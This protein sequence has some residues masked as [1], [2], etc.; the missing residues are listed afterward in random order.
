MKINAATTI[1]TSERASVNVCF[2]C[3]NAIELCKSALNTSLENLFRVQR[4]EQ[5]LPYGPYYIDWDRTWSRW[6]TPGPARH[7]QTQSR[8]L[9]SFP[10]L[11]RPNH[12]VNNGHQRTWEFTLRLLIFTAYLSTMCHRCK[13][14]QTLLFGPTL[15]VQRAVTLAMSEFASSAQLHS[16]SLLRLR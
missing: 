5:E 4:N 8:H 10:L 7:C 13:T 16:L 9:V 1:A 2:I 15:H 12:H 3:F 6:H 11:V 14:P